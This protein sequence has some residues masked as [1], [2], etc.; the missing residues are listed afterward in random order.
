[1]RI[2]DI[3]IK[4]LWVGEVAAMAGGEA[5]KYAIRVYGLDA[6]VVLRAK[7]E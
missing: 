1:M 6:V 2:Y 5:R 4:D 7:G 3:F